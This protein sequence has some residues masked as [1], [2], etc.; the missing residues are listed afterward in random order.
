MRPTPCGRATMCTVAYT[1][2]YVEP[3]GRDWLTER[4]GLNLL[5]LASTDKDSN[6]QCQGKASSRG[7]P[8]IMDARSGV[9]ISS[10]SVV[11]ILSRTT[12][13]AH[14]QHSWDSRVY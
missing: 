14:S 2:D 12:H 7:L 8:V 6:Q 9:G 5:S 13:Y 1:Q 3:Q 11:R 10:V 4:R